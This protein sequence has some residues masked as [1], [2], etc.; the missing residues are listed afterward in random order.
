MR[1]YLRLHPIPAQE[2]RAWR[3]PMLAARVAEGIDE[4]RSRLLSLIDVE[5][6]ES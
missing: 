4:E 5:L 2:L 1:E 6:G 3:L